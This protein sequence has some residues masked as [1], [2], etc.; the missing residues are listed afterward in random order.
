MCYLKK[1]VSGIFFK[2]N[3][4]RDEKANPNNLI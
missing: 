2:G 1:A 4:E 3:M